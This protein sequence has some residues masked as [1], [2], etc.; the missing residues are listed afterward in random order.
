MAREIKKDVTLGVQL[1]FICGEC[2]IPQKHV[3][4]TSYEDCIAEEGFDSQT[5]YQIVQ[6]LNCEAICFRSEYEDSESHSYDMSTG[7]DFYWSTE[8][9]FP[10]RTAGRFKIKDSFTLPPGVGKAY[11]ELVSAMN[12][13]QTILA[14]LG[15]RVVLESICVDLKAEGDSLFKKING[16]LK[17]NAITESDVSILHKLRALGNTAAHEAKPSSPEQL[18]LA[19]NVIEHLLLGTYI[20]PRLASSVFRS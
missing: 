12:A 13:G 16:L 2:R 11:D 10:H 7:E 19:M 1:K 17:L 14:G 9:I 5:S 4:L 20:H 15:I 18:D 8:H 3:V 6:C